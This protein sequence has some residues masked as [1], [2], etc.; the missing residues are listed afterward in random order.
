MADGPVTT[1]DQTEAPKGKG[2]LSRFK[3]P[4]ASIPPENKTTPA[5]VEALPFLFSM[6]PYKPEYPLLWKVLQ[7]LILPMDCLP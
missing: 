5:K 3:K 1:P 4:V 6:P 7:I 2:I